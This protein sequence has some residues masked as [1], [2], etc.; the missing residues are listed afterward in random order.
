METTYPRGS[1]YKRI[2]QIG[3]GE[4]NGKQ[5]I[6]NEFIINHISSKNVFISCLIASRVRTYRKISHNDF[7]LYIKKYIKIN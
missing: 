2:I 5:F 1:K 3:A 7:N 6:A 4:L